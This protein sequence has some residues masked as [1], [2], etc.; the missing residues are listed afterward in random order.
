MTYFKYAE[1]LNTKLVEAS[2]LVYFIRLR[3][4]VIGVPSSVYYKYLNKKLNI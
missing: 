2:I 3:E 1:V 4:T